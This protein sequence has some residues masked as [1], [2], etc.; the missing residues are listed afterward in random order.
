MLQGNLWPS[1]A[2][3]VV[4]QRAASHKQAQCVRRYEARMQA[5]GGGS[6]GFDG[7]GDDRD[8]AEGGSRGSDA[9]SEVLTYR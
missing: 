8:G 6:G 9:D 7:G 2:L 3:L 5:K 1:L 4:D